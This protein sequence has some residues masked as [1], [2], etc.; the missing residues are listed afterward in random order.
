MKY[1]TTTILIIMT[2]VMGLYVALSEEPKEAPDSGEKRVFDGFQPREATAVVWK[3]DD[4]EI[5]VEKKDG[6]WMIV[7]PLEFP[8]DRDGV[9][10]LLT[11]FETLIFS[12]RI[13][14]DV[15][16]AEYGLSEPKVIIKVEGALPGGKEAFLRV[17]GSDLTE[18]YIYVARGKKDEALVVS[19]H[20]KNT[21]DKGL[22]DIRS[23]DG[24]TFDYERARRVLLQSDIDNDVR[25]EKTGKTYAI[26]DDDGAVKLRAHRETMEDIM[27]RI[28]TL[29][30]TRF[31]A[32]GEDKPAE[33]GL[34]EASRRIVVILDEG[35]EHELLIRGEC[36]LDGKTYEG[37]LM[38]AR[39]QP[40]PAVFC[41]SANDVNRILRPMEELR[42]IRLLDLTADELEE[43]L[44]EAA[45]D[46]LVLRQVDRKWMLGGPELRD[47]VASGDNEE[48]EKEDDKAEEDGDRS[49]FDIIARF[50]DEIQ[51]FSA[52]GFA[53]PDED[54]QKDYGLSPPD[55]TLT[56]KTENGDEHVL[57]MGAATEQH[58]YVQRKGERGVVV[59]HKELIRRFRPD[60]LAFRH[61]GV[62]EFDNMDL[63]KIQARRAGVEEVLERDEG[64][65]K[66]IK[67]V[68]I[69]AD[70][71]AVETLVRVAGQLKAE[72]YVS[73]AA[74]PE[75]GLGTRDAHIL[76]FTVESPPVF[77]ADGRKKEGSGDITV[78]ELEI[79][80]AGPARG[81]FGR[82][83]SGDRAVF[84]LDEL[85]CSDLRAFLADKNLLDFDTSASRSVSFRG[86][87]ITEQLEKRGP[88]WHRKAG[89]GVDN[90]EVEN[91]IGLAVGLRA[92]EVSGYLAPRDLHGGRNP[93]ITVSIGTEKGEKQTLFVG[94]EK[95]EG[96]GDRYCWV[97]GRN[98]VYVI[99]SANVK[100]LEDVSL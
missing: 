21:L 67:P 60:R 4:V 97:E 80:P 10:A 52:L 1:V 51:A 94:S 27:R 59:V 54:A 81:C 53:F 90:I 56:F 83:L 38:A 2:L 77:G 50:V 71:D 88:Q 42:D 82:L 98:I 79:G 29:K 41:L 3:R 24:L 39:M 89:P 23:K 7:A 45:G 33:H 31:I 92:R 72:R 65:W 55:A 47:K 61:R 9:E 22:D 85:T 84:R 68:E 30:M 5:R 78:H 74:R 93:Y 25:V 16:R 46:E 15:D 44:I 99:S 57:L 12:R 64:E 58:L 69:K 40:S 32:S 8:A 63:K 86:P 19:N 36:V 11:D 62:L 18:R 34:D 35:E 87:G 91:F 43:I 13:S 100:R 48:K 28:E 26:V 37:E 96:K 17:G 76:S 14:K 75:H 6:R 73:P 95:D 49:D 66:L 20:V 70:R